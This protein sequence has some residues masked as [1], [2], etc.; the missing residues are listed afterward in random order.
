MQ[1]RFTLMLPTDGGI[2]RRKVRIEG[3]TSSIRLRM[4]AWSD[5]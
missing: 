1:A 5:C 2:S 4:T 3:L